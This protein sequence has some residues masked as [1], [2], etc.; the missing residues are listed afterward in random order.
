MACPRKRVR[1]AE[2]VGAPTAH[3]NADSNPYR[4]TPR[5]AHLTDSLRETFY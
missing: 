2:L 5:D 3:T 4:F 1:E